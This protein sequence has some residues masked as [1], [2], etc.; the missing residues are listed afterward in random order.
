LTY[1]TNEYNINR[2]IELLESTNIYT[3]HYNNQIVITDEINPLHWWHMSTLQL[4]SI[5]EHGKGSI[6]K[7]LNKACKYLISG[8]EDSNDILTVIKFINKYP[9]I[10]WY[11]K[12]QAYVLLKNKDPKIF[13]KIV[14]TLLLISKNIIPSIKP[15]IKLIMIKVFTI[16]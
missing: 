11:L 8:I 10:H 12:L 14:I 13:K 3:E 9:S 6:K 4:A 1:A 2:G 15:F 16:I 7:D 5:F